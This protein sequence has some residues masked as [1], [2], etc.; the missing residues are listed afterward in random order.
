MSDLTI[1]YDEHHFVGFGFEWGQPAADVN[2]VPQAPDTFDGYNHLDYPYPAA[3]EVP[4][5]QP[6][7]SPPTEDDQAAPYPPHV[8]AFR[9]RFDAHSNVVRIEVPV[10]CPR[11]G[12][13][14]GRE[15]RG[16]ARPLARRALF[17]HQV[18]DEGAVRLEWVCLGDDAVCASPARAG[19]PPALQ[20][21]ALSLLSY[22]G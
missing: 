22:D 7:P 11:P 12:L 5:V 13:R 16:A 2:C 6:S 8:D 10:T 4:C 19:Q 21:A 14:R 1:S 18:H 20:E 9:T 17:R 3:D 15:P